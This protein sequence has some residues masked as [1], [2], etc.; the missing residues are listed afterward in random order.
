M[1]IYIYKIKI[2]E[3]KIK[4]PVAKHWQ[5]FSSLQISD[6]SQAG[7]YLNPTK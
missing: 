7:I 4:F 1:Y 6:T 5:R 3:I 2:K